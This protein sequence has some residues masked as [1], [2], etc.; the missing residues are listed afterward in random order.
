MWG[1]EGHDSV[2]SGGVESSRSRIQLVE[3][4]PGWPTLGG[5]VLVKG[6]K[7]EDR[8]CGPPVYFL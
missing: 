2:W 7:D 1:T 6:K 4:I 5:S 8:E 3:T